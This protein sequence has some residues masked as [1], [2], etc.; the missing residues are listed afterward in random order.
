[1]SSAFVFNCPLSR[2]LACLSV[3]VVFLY[4]SKFRGVKKMEKECPERGGRK[5]NERRPAGN[6]KC[7]PGTFRTFLF[8]FVF[9]VVVPLC[10]SFLIALPEKV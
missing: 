5:E 2:V 7:L 8:R 10:Q 9:D 1:M 3:V 4:Y 6:L